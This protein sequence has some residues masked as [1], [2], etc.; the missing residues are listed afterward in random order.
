M[1]YSAEELRKCADHKHNEGCL[2]TRQ[3][4][5]YAADVIERQEQVVNVLDDYKE[6]GYR[7]SGSY[8]AS[9]LRGQR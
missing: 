3:M 1:A 5:R 9:I 2:T 7:I 4:L 6:S 8:I